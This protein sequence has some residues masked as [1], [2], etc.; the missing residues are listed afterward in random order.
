MEGGHAQQNVVSRGQHSR[1]PQ[2][3]NS[4][5]HATGVKQGPSPRAPSLMHAPCS[6]PGGK[7]S[8]QNCA[9]ALL[10]SPSGCARAT[11]GTEAST[12]PTRAPPNTRSAWRLETVP[13]ASPLASSSKERSWRFAL[14][15]VQASKGCSSVGL[16]SSFWSGIK[17]RLPS[18]P[19]VGS[20]GT[21]LA[22]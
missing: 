1:G 21:I 9:Q 3:S 6:G 15:L 18:S 22:L 13:W 4:A 8:R 20:S 5:S 12:P 17:P 11:P 10:S 2:G 19:E 16:R 14:V 7:V